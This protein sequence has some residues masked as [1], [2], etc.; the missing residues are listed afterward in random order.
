MS[1]VKYFCKEKLK[2]VL[3]VHSKVEERC[4][5]EY[6]MNL[7]LLSRGL[8]RRANVTEKCLGDDCL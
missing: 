8:I 1:F 3:F 4:D 6:T 7:N 5:V 2:D